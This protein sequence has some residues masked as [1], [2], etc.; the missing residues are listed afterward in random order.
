MSEP[1]KKTVSIVGCGWLGFPLAIHLRESGYTTVKGSTTTPEKLPKLREAGIDAYVAALD[2]NPQGQNWPELLQ[3]DILV[4][5][6][7][8]RRSQ[9]GGDF[10]PR[11]M[12][13][14]AAMIEKS[15]ISEIIHVSSTS[16]YPELSQTMHEDDV[17]NP[18][19]SAS[20]RLMEAEQIMTSLRKQGRDVSVLRC[21]GLMG[22]DRIP[23][24]YVRGK[25]D[26][27][28]G[29]VPVNYTHR[30][31]VVAIISKLLIQGVNN[32]T[33]NVVAPEH[34]TRRSIY[35]KSCRDYGWELPTFAE[36]EHPEPFK[37]VSPEKIISLL[38]YTFIYSNPLEFFYL[39]SFK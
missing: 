31:D 18:E 2:P 19:E 36:P 35:E 27:T 4:V 38:D 23:G 15:P 34:P 28:T 29:E 6:I 22:Y 3:A 9:Q 30:D 37:I 25:K 5:D 13:N 24:K 21:G 17:T 26:I 33:F 32:E 16:I 1:I 14:L 10:H 20:P 11:Q 12:R 8:P 39:S 7:P